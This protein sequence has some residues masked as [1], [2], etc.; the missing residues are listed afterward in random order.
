[1]KSNGQ[2]QVV[3][4]MF[5]VCLMGC[6]QM[7]ASRH[8]SDYGLCP[9]VRGDCEVI[10]LEYPAFDS[11]AAISLPFD[12]VADTV[13]LSRDIIRDRIISNELV[14]MEYELKLEMSDRL[15]LPTLRNR[16]YDIH[17]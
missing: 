1:M 13:M 12:L 11:M 8:A 16:T 9:G 3:V 5:L 4:I 6:G 15:H 2:C 17:P 10:R 14:I 7:N